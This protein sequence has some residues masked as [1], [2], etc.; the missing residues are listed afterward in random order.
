M[1][2]SPDLLQ[3]RHIF[4]RSYL[5]LLAVYTSR[6]KASIQS[7][8][9]EIMFVINS[10]LN[11]MEAVVHEQDEMEIILGEMLCTLN[12]TS[13]NN[14]AEKCFSTWMSSRMGDEMVIKILLKVLTRNVTD[15]DIVGKILENMV[16]TYFFNRGR[17]H[18]F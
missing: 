13:I 18:V 6:H 14:V 5:K 10:Q 8:E 9:N 7:K 17:C 4:V 16:S 2:L 1:D 12:F 15:C 11:H 3:K